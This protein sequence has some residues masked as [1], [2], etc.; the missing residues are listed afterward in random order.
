MIII[1]ITNHFTALN[2]RYDVGD[3]LLKPQST[4]PVTPNINQRI[5]LMLVI[6]T[7]T[8]SIY[9]HVYLSL[10]VLCKCVCL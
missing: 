3:T 6:N 8:A 4:L 10:T 1:N 9:I 7:G 5:I 2:W